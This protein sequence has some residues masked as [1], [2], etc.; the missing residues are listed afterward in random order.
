MRIH[1]L[2]V[3]AFG[4][5]SGSEVI[6]FDKLTD[7]GLFLLCG[8]TGAGK[9]SVLDAICFGLYG[10]VPGDRNSAKRLRSDHAAS[11]V[12][13]AVSLEVSISGRRFRL[14]RSPAWHRSKRRGSGTT[15]EHARANLEELV[16]GAWVH[17]SNRLDETGHLITE[18]LGMN[19]TQ[20]CQVAML[21]QGRFQSFLRAQSDERHKLLQQL[22]RASRFEDIERWLV[23]RR[24]SLKVANQGH[25]EAVA[26]VVSRVS[27]AAAADIPERWDIHE[28]TA[29]ATE[30]AVAAWATDLLMSTSRAR[31]E[32]DR[33]LRVLT[34]NAE[35]ARARLSEVDRIQAQRTRHDQAIRREESLAKTQEQAEG[36]RTR[37]DAA[38]RARAVA[39]LLKLAKEA[40]AAADASW[41]NLGDVLADAAR[42]LG[43]DARYLTTDD[44]AFAERD[45]RDAASIARAFLPREVELTSARATIESG[46]TELTE[47]QDTARE[48]EERCGRLPT[49][50]AQLRRSLTEQSALAAGL[51]AVDK[52]ESALRTQ[53]ADAEKL[54]GLRA[55]LVRAR[56]QHRA[57]I[58]GAQ[59]L[60]EHMH[61][62][63]EARINGMAAELAITLASGDAC[64]VCGSADHPAVARAVDG[65]PMRGDEEAARSAYEDAEFTRQ[66]N[67]ELVAT[68]D[69]SCVMA[70]HSSGGKTAEA[71]HAEL[72]MAHDA[73]VAC[74]EA[75]AEQGRLG[76]RI[77]S[78]DEE[79][80][81]AQRSSRLISAKIA[82]RT[83]QRDHA[84]V[85][86]ER[87]SAELAQLFS[88]TEVSDSIERLIEAKSS[89]GAAYAAAREA[90]S[91]RDATLAKS[92]DAHQHADDCASEH[93]FDT[94]EAAFSALLTR[95][96][97]QVLEARLQERERQRIQVAAV[98]EDT[99]VKAAVEATPSDV[100]DLKAAATGAEEALAECAAT[101]R[102][103][104]DREGRLRRL[105]TELTR[106]LDNWAPTRSA[107]S[108]TQSVST[109]VEGKGGDNGLQMRLSAYVL[110]ERL[111]QVVAAANERLWTMSDHR[112]TLEHSAARGVG[113]LRGG[114]SLLIRDEWTG[115]S[116]DPATLSGGETFVASLA[117][118]LGLAD[119]VTQEAGGSNIDTLF[120]DEGFGTLDP[121][122]LDDVMDTL[123][124]L[125]DGGRVVGIVSHV[126]EMR[127]RVSSQLQIRKERSGS[128][129]VAAREPG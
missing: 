86:V 119:V 8:P 78:L 80:D 72:S 31:A 102:V 92:R 60:R 111:K 122:T 32:L 81:V 38:E 128:R 79:L 28:L 59:A 51:D 62:V 20:F 44:L 39:P 73:R 1:H 21:P 48:L 26:A 84:Q 55:K 123:D 24:Q 117:L 114:L 61:D 120:I 18:L 126:P 63:R 87:V 35:D 85:V 16:E 101:A 93:G 112:Y 116:R 71:L 90:L 96:D 23:G 29:P 75:A 13:P 3:T 77:E 42:R 56:Q 106:Q 118:A 52:A 33:E 89:A 53:L 10:A 127:T 43:A 46:A 37:L 121:E 99:E 113:E 100:S 2:E 66:A 107:Y 69:Q 88:G 58:D 109:F 104:A 12:A 40:G 95:G 65:A 27:E 82:R 14:S 115:E 9:T 98:L 105:R 49:E 15:I 83:Q 125:R 19:L 36:M 67:A 34:G 91:A 57:S 17:H 45:A 22:F 50:V 68:L 11:E 41:R 30:G 124:G 7:S 5:F 54:V 129:V 74:R 70:Q 103:V 64:P 25:Q 4:P 108:L 97:I 47:L 6:N 94:H 110:A 76:S